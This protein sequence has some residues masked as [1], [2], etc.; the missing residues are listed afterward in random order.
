[1]KP[2]MNGGNVCYYTPLEREK[3]NIGTCQGWK[4]A[5]YAELL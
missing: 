2:K 4:E 1:M 3:G 5:L